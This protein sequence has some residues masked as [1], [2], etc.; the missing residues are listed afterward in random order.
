MCNGLTIMTDSRHG[1]E[2]PEHHPGKTERRAFWVTERPRSRASSRDVQNDRQARPTMLDGLQVQRAVRPRH[3][4]RF[5][6]PIAS[7]SLSQRA[8]SSAGKVP[9]KSG[10]VT[11]PPTVLGVDCEAGETPVDWGDA[12]WMGGPKLAWVVPTVTAIF[13]ET[14]RPFLASVY[15]MLIVPEP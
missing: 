4:E 1:G 12:V 2:M 14:E 13:V 15:F 8:K 3:H 9:D 5:S 10:E 11:V 6:S 7:I